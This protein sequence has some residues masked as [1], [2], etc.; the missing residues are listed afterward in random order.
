MA[1]ISVDRSIPQVQG[2]ASDGL[3]A[4]GFIHFWGNSPA[5]DMLGD[6]QTDFYGVAAKGT[7]EGQ[8]F[9]EKREEENAA[10]EA[11][12]EAYFAPEP[13]QPTEP[14]AAEPAPVPEDSTVN[15]LVAGGADIRHLLKTAARRRGGGTGPKLRFFLH[16]TQHEVLA[17]HILFLQLINNKAL[18]V[19]ER[20]ETFLSLY[21]NTL[22]R[23]KDCKYVAELADELIEFVTDN[24]EHPIANVV[25]LDHLKFKDRDVLH[26]VFR[27][28]RADAPF[29]V[30]ALREQR[31]RGYYRDRYDY[32]KNM[33][34]M[35]YVTHIKNKAGI[36]N[37]FH[38]KAFCF[39][40]VAF[41]TRLAS[42][43]TCNRTLASYTEGKDRT[44]GTTIQVRGFWGDIINSPFY[45]FSTTTNK[46]DKPRLFKISGSQ[47][48]QTESD[49]AE[50]NVTDY[51]QQLDSGEVLHLPPERPEEHTFPYA[52]PLEE[53]QKEES[54]IEEV[55]EEPPQ[56]AAE[57]AGG[58]AGSRRS[59]RRQ[60]KPKKEWPPLT[61]AFEDGGVEVVLLTGD[62][63]ETLRKPRYH[64]LFHRAFLGAMAAMPMLEEAGL[65]EASK[66]PFRPKDLEVVRIRR[67]PR[68]EAPELFGTRALD[69]SLARVMAEGAEVVAETLKYQAHFDGIARLA[70]RHRLA[71]AGHLFGW[72]TANEARAVPRMEHDMKEHGACDVERN[73]ADFVRLVTGPVPP[74]PEADS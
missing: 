31:C 74:L 36:I 46:E 57:A 60:A 4:V 45:A 64:G 25:R 22:V 71:Q 3:D 47:Y 44:K 12:E 13:E 16:E 10:R 48:R 51:L 20:M 67:A 5:L 58:A 21:G 55:S 17:R 26:E 14:A 49:I 73:A 70:F 27:G 39:T 23:E 6:E 69:S 33:M 52:S 18:P 24:S 54:K 42:Y 53:M 50:F 32:R 34:D 28:W 68:L 35:D 41:E 15:I 59:G 56:A 7:S 66:D 40:G 2:Q 30:E 9:K 38:Y 61:A 11:K 8:V 62:L 1:R 19:R 72:R 29:D 63:R 65:K 37:W 43:N